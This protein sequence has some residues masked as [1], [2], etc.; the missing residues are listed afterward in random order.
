MRTQPLEHDIEPPTSLPAASVNCSG[1]QKAYRK[2]L[3]DPAPR[4]RLCTGFRP[5]KTVA[6]SWHDM[7]FWPPFDRRRI[8]NICSGA[9][10]GIPGAPE[11]DCWLWVR[12]CDPP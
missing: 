3:R 5:S 4:A 2:S 6:L 7:S 11:I 9:R 1:K 12:T 8:G 10:Y